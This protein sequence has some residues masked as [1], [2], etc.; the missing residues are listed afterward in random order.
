MTT[1]TVAFL[2]TRRSVLARNMTTPGPDATQLRTLLEIGARVPDH[3]KLAPWRFL[4]FSGAARTAFDDRLRTVYTQRH[5]EADAA[6]IATS[7]T[8]MVRAPLVIGVVSSPKQHPK[9]PD[10]EQ[11]LSAGAACQNILIAAQSMGFAAQWLTQWYAYDETVHAH[12]GLSGTERLAGFIYVGTAVEPP[13]ERAR[14]DVD[15]LTTH[16]DV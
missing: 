11:H 7:C 5:P 9:I 3:G 14:P 1:D 4:V 16:W 8:C 13:K 12:L 2:Q 10:W 15:E 6:D